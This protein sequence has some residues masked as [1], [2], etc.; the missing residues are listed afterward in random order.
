MTYYQ[1]NPS[2]K[3]E[4]ITYDD[5]LPPVHY[6]AVQPGVYRHMALEVDDAHA[7]EQR[8]RQHDVPII[9]PP[10]YSDKLHSI[11]MLILDPNG[12]EIELVQR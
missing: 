1:L 5:Q 6:P 12:V 11:N 2:C 8:L 4:L 3:L 7:Y 9:Y 10:Q